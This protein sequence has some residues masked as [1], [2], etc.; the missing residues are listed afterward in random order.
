MPPLNHSLGMRGFCTRTT[1]YITVHNEKHKFFRL[2]KYLQR[3]TSLHQPTPQQLVFELKRQ[4]FV[5]LILFRPPLYTPAPSIHGKR[6]V[7]LLIIIT[8]SF[9]IY[10]GRLISGHEMDLKEILFAPSSLV[11]EVAAAA[12]LNGRRWL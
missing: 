3:I 5:F 4:Q 8:R 6:T 1:L 9:R 7:L 11:L 2:P 10:Y 12:L